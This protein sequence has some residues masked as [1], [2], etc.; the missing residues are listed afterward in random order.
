MLPGTS[1]PS[2]GGGTR[3]PISKPQNTGS[4]RLQIAATAAAFS[5]DQVVAH[6]WLVI[7]EQMGFGQGHRSAVPSLISAGTRGKGRKSSLQ[8]S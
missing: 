6:G 3:W 7:G 5:F 1:F 4:R 2:A 8:A